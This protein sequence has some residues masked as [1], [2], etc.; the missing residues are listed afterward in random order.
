MKI[1]GLLIG[2]ILAM[3]AVY[4][5]F[6]AKVADNKGGLQI[7]VDKYLQTKIKLT[8]VNLES[9]SR[10]VL[11]YAA[12]GPGLPE[13]LDVLQRSR[14]TAVALSDAWGRKIRYERLSDTSFRLRSAGPDG[15]FETADDIVKD[16]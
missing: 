3:I 1:R 15:A 7:E 11:M 9:I 13:G 4:F 10:E 14:P 8:A 5:I 16:F 12:D 6:F 2:V